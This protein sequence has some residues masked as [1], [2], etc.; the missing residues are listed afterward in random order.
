MW[1]VAHSIALD[2]LCR[3]TDGIIL[4]RIYLGGKE[5]LQTMHA[6]EIREFVR[7]VYLSEELK[8][9]VLGF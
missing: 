4:L 5:S 9:P 1:S 8:I 7:F 3:K 2:M 6:H